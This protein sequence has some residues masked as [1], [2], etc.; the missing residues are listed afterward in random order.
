MALSPIPLCV[1]WPLVDRNFVV[2]VCVGAVGGA[3][4]AA[5]Q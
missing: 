3:L 5:R 2:K 4:A 1:V